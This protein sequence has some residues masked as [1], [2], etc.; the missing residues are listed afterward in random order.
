MAKKIL[1]KKANKTVKKTAKKAIKKKVIKKKAV[2]KKA[3]KKKAVK[4]TSAKKTKNIAKVVKKKIVK[5]SKKEVDT[6]K[7]FPSTHVS[8]DMKKTK[9]AKTK[10]IG[11]DCIYCSLEEGVYCMV[12]FCTLNGSEQPRKI[13]NDGFSAECPHYKKSKI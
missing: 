2:K 8:P 10:Y 1:K 11:S 9:K 6:R 7:A 5:K 4:K 12:Y 3:A 13:C